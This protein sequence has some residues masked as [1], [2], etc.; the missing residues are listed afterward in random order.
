MLQAVYAGDY[1]IAKASSVIA[2]LNN[3]QVIDILSHVLE[4]LVKGW[5]RTII[6]SLPLNWCQGH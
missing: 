3:T 1:I 6:V 5:Y 4:D 2:R